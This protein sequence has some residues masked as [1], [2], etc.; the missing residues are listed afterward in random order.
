MAGKNGEEDI[1]RS[2]LVAADHPQAS[3][4]NGRPVQIKGQQEVPVRRGGKQ[5]RYVQPGRGAAYPVNWGSVWKKWR[6]LSIRCSSLCTTGRDEKKRKPRH[7][8]D[9]SLFF[10]IIFLTVFGLVTIYSASLIQP[11]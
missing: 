5:A 6:G 1:R 2:L 3:R 4:Q 9:Y 8:Y 10:I 7:F 11:S